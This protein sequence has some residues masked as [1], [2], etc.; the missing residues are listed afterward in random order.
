MTRNTHHSRLDLNEGHRITRE[1]TE[2]IGRM[3]RFSVLSE[4]LR[5]F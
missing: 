5:S 1:T 2:E 4:S 3:R